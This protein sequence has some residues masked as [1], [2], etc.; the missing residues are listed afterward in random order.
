[1]PALRIIIIT[2]TV[3]TL[4]IWATM[5]GVTELSL[6]ETYS[7]PS[8]CSRHEESGM[9]LHPYPERLSQGE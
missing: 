6:V 8:D 2:H 3:Y 4:V 5:V 7:I 1:M 9:P